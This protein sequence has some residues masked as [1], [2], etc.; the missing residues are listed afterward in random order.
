MRSGY[1]IADAGR[2]DLIELDAAPTSRSSS[3]PAYDDGRDFGTVARRSST[4]WTLRTRGRTGHSSGVFGS[5]LGY[6]AIYELARILDGFRRELPEPNLT[7]NVGVMAGGTPAEIDA[8]GFRVAASGKTN[9]IAETAVARGDI[10]TLSAEQETRIRARMQ[11]IVA[12]H[13][14]QTEAELVFA[15][16]G[17]PP[18]A[19]TEGNRA[20]LARLNAVNRDPACPRCPNMTRPGAAPPI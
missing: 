1:K 10:R 20:L 11:E 17:Y 9:I 18:M 12:Q 4:S 6:G 19:P 8:D 14:P 5:G 13:L 7:Y 3:R 2:R 15:A 16:D